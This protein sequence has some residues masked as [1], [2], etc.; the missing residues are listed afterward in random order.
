MRSPCAEAGRTRD[1]PV[2]LLDRRDATTGGDD[3]E[4]RFVTRNRCRLT[5]S[6]I[7]REWRSG[8]IGPL[9]LVDVRRVQ[10]GGEGTQSDEFGMRRRDRVTVKSR[11]KSV[12][13]VIKIRYYPALT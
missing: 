6:Q 5:A 1:H 10:R 13:D 3:L 12:I 7:G 9:D 2:A 11:T 4:A 8:R